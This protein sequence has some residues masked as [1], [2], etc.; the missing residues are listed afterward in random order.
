[1][2]EP[3]LEV[4]ALGDDNGAE[5]FADLF[6]RQQRGRSD[7]SAACLAFAFAIADQIA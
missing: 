5:A 3:L 2:P 1:M 6:K 7:H 4:D